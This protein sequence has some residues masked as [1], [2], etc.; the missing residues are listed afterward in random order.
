MIERWM[1]VNEIAAHLGIAA[2]TIYRWLEK[3]LIPAHKVGKQ[4]RFNQAEVDAWV[5]S[6]SPHMTTTEAANR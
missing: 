5:M 4:W 3:G 1:S 6:K 2:I